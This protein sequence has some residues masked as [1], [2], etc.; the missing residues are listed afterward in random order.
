MFGILTCTV[1]FSMFKSRALTTVD[2]LNNK[3][4][5][6]LKS[7]KNMKTKKIFNAELSMDSYG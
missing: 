3:K 5:K 7:V 4:R 1:F 2:G 6:N